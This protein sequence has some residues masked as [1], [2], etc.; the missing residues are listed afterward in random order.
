MIVKNIRNF[1]L[2]L[3]VLLLANNSHLDQPNI[4]ANHNNNS[5][6]Q[7]QSTYSESVDSLEKSDH[8]FFSP[9][10][11]NKQ[12]PINK[13]TFLL[14]DK[15]VLQKCTQTSLEMVVFSYK[16]LCPVLFHNLTSAN[17]QVKFSNHHKN[18]SQ[19]NNN[20]LLNFSGGMFV[21]STNLKKKI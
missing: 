17:D 2:S 19:S 1:F 15:K 8:N 10:D 11:L 14:S 3:L 7:Q 21:F 18:L 12:K 4:D 13:N 20:L 16:R 5:A 6:V 9:T